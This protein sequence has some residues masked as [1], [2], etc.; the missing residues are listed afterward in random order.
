M[1]ADSEVALRREVGGVRRIRL[2]DIETGGDMLGADKSGDVS[3]MVDKVLYVR[4]RVGFP[5]HETRKRVDANY[6]APTR[7]SANSVIG[8]VAWVIA[9][10]AGVRMADDHR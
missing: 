7:H 8:E 10:G 4:L 2:I 5:K 3:N 1:T 6:A 9:Q